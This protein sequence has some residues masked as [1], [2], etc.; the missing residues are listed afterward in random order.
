MATNVGYYR[1]V[2]PHI[3]RNLLAMLFVANAHGYGFQ[4]GDE[5]VPGTVYQFVIMQH[6]HD[7]PLLCIRR[8]EA[9]SGNK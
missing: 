2:S 8:F 7:V 5:W 3:R 1:F 4:Y 9:I 6:L